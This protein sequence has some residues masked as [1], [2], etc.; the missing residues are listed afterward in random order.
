MLVLGNNHIGLALW[1]SFE[2]VWQVLVNRQ[3]I[4]GHGVTH[5]LKPILRENEV[6]N[7]NESAQN[8]GKKKW[9]GLV[10]S[11]TN[12]VTG[13]HLVGGLV[14]EDPDVVKELT[15]VEQPETIEEH[16]NRTE[17]ENVKHRLAEG[18]I[19]GWWL[20]HVVSNL[21]SLSQSLVRNDECCHWEHDWHTNS[22]HQSKESDVQ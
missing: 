7:D 6:N 1:Q 18:V 19:H 13:L 16:D 4:T 22:V 3:C 5:M 21:H 10:D 2:E 9:R 15:I 12:K 17:L 14:L 8:T 20:S 11:D